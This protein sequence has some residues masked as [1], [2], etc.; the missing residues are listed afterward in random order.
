[1][2]TTRRDVYYSQDKKKVPRG[3]RK[4]LLTRAV[5]RARV[6]DSSKWA[7]LTLAAA[8]LSYPNPT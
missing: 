6:R 3:V 8:T 7:L 2:H 4:K 5:P 1:M